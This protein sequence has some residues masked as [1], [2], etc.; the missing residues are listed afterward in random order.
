MFRLM[1]ASTLF[2]LPSCVQS[3]EPWAASCIRE[4]PMKGPL[5][6]KWEERYLIESGY[7]VSYAIDNAGHLAF[8]QD[9]CH[10]TTSCEVHVSPETVSWSSVGVIQIGSDDDLNFVVT[11]TSFSMGRRNIDTL[12]AIGNKRI[13]RKDEAGKLI[14]ILTERYLCAP[15]AV[16][17]R[18]E[19]GQLF[20]DEVD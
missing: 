10:A 5:V 11:E 16:P 9:V 18:S 4:N 1:M 20:G 17:R 7:I 6:D 14:G 12:G 15:A 8:V 3:E 13:V 19:Q 2:V